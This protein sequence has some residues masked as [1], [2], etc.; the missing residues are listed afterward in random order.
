MCAAG[1]GGMSRTAQYLRYLLAQFEQL[2]MIKLY[3]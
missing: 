1:E 3:R 2:R